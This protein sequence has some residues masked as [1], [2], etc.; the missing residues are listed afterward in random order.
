MIIF[1]AAECYTQRD[2]PRAVVIQREIVVF[3]LNV[4]L[5]VPVLLPNKTIFHPRLV[6]H[7]AFYP[8]LEHLMYVKRVIPF[9]HDVKLYRNM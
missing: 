4:V 1:I 5:A 8:L 3:R 2:T 9:C 6:P 7:Y